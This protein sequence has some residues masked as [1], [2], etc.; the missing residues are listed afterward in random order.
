MKSMPYKAGEPAIEEVLFMR[1]GSRSPSLDCD[2]LIT[3]PSIAI[4]L[5]VCPNRLRYRLRVYFLNLFESEK[6]KS[7]C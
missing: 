4:A 3:V 6:S 2:P 5:G 1:Y 7:K